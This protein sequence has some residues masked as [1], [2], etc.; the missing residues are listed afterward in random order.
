MRRLGKPGIRNHWVP[1]AK[2]AKQPKTPKNRCEGE[3]ILLQPGNFRN[4]PI[5]AKPLDF[6]SGC[7]YR[8]VW[9][10]RAGQ[11]DSAAC[12]LYGFL[13]GSLRVPYGACH[14]LVLT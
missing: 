9:I 6:K 8:N 14:I 1:I 2:H 10:A 4:Q 12:D 5:L 7:M 11:P 3:P 13:L